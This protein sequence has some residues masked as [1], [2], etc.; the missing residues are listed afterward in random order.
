MHARTHAINVNMRQPVSKQSVREFM[1]SK[2]ASQFIPF[3]YFNDN[4]S[5]DALKKIK[6]VF[7]CLTTL[8]GIVT[9]EH[10][11]L[12]QTQVVIV[13]LLFIRYKEYVYNVL[14]KCT[15]LLWCAS[16]TTRTS[17]HTTSIIRG[18]MHFY[19]IVR[20]RLSPSTLYLTINTFKDLHLLE[21]TGTVGLNITSL[22]EA[23]KKIQIACISCTCQTTFTI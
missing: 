20:H 1:Y 16:G 3:S 19:W 13:L 9:A 17:A 18:F 15:P 4:S 12:R 21:W 7:Y 5:N 6:P 11:T 2:D 22:T 10:K 14:D 23:S 8:T